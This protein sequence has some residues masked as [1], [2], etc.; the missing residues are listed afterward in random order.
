MVGRQGVVKFAKVFKRALFSFRPTKLVVDLLWV[1]GCALPIQ[2]LYLFLFSFNSPVCLRCLFCSLFVCLFEKFCLY[3]LFLN[4]AVCL[5]GLLQIGKIL[6]YFQFYLASLGKQRVVLPVQV[7]PLLCL[8]DGIIQYFQLVSSGD[9]I[10]RKFQKKVVRS[11]K[12]TSDRLFFTLRSLETDNSLTLGRGSIPVCEETSVPLIFLASHDVFQTL[13]LLSGFLLYLLVLQHLINQLQL[14][15][16]LFDLLFQC[17][18][19]LQVSLLVFGQLFH[20]LVTQCVRFL[21]VV[22]SLYG[23]LRCL[24]FVED[25]LDGFTI[26]SEV[27]RVGQL[28]QDILTFFFVSCKKVGKL[29]LCKHR[30]ASK[31]LEVESNSIFNDLFV[32]FGPVVTVRLYMPDGSVVLDD[33]MAFRVLFSALYHSQCKTG[34]IDFAVIAFE[35]HF[36]I[37]LVFLGDAQ[38]SVLF[39]TVDVKTF[40]LIVGI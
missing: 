24:G 7:Y 20:L 15:F 40:S 21:C 2:P 27:L 31:L 22:L 14:V 28:L 26:G 30:H 25:A 5:S 34:M 18:L 35:D 37:A 9:E 33:I 23:G 16:L 13:F 8:T 39:K 4:R 19:L 6:I 10:S 11:L 3:I 1:E 12:F 17:F 32:S 38:T 36:T 29:P